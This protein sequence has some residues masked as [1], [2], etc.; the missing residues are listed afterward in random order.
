MIEE[1]FEDQEDVISKSQIKREMHALKD[2]GKELVKL[3]PVQLEKMP[4]SEELRSNVLEAK[5]FK[6]KAL[7]RQLQRI[8][9]LMREAD[10]DAIQKALNR[11][12][13]PEKQQIHEFHKIEKWREGLIAGESQTMDELIEQFSEIDHQYINQMIRNAK[14]EKSQN[15]T[16]KSSR[17]LFQYL[18]SLHNSNS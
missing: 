6:Q 5:K 15:K 16:P 12:H 1:N 4:V 18:Q 9:V 13:R 17:A 2:L 11:L 3:T 7:K 8:G 10:A 14:K